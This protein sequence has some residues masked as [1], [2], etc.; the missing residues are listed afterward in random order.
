MAEFAD[1]YSKDKAGQGKLLKVKFSV[2]ARRTKGYLH[3]L[4][5]RL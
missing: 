5:L 1:Q 2:S 3:C 4:P